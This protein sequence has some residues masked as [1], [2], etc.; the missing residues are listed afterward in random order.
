MTTSEQEIGI[1]TTD[2][3]LVVRSWDAWLARVTGISADVARGQPL[4]QLVPEL[5]SRGL[6]RR[7]ERVLA[8]GVVEVLAPAFHRHLIACAPQVPS[9]HFSTMQQWVTIAPLREGEWVVGTIVTVEDVTARLER[10]RELAG[11]L[12]SPDESIRLQAA[13]ALEAENAP[14]ELLVGALGDQSWRVRQSAVSGLA[15]HGGPQALVALLRALREQH[16]DPSVLNS[17]LQALALSDGDVVAPLVECLGA[18]EADLRIYA[19]L[20]LGERHDSL[21]ISA[22]LGALDDPD[23]NVRYHAIEA[24]GK[25]RAAEAVDTLLAIANSGDFFLAFPAIDALIRIGDTRAASRLAP[26][27]E[28]PLL[29]ALTAEAL[30]QLGDEAAVEP[31]VTL[32]NKPGAPALAIVQAL[33]GLHDRYEQSYGEGSYIADLARQSIDA[34]GAHNVLD[35][36]DQAPP[37]EL[38]ALVLVLGWLDGPAVQRTLA[39]LLG[40][41]AVRKTVVEA[42][43]RH[44]PRVTD[45]LIEQLAAEDLETR[46]AAALALGRIGDARA[47]P[48]LILALK[49]APELAMTAAG[50]LGAIGDRRAFEA[51]LDL[52]GHPIAAVRQAA[53]GALNS[54]G[55]PDLAACTLTLLDSP[56]PQVRESA[57][58]IAGYFG[59]DSCVDAV[60]AR[61]DDPD[62]RVRRAA[63]EHLPY[64]EDPRVL[65]ALAAALCSQSTGARAAAARALGQVEGASAAPHLLAALDDADPWV[66]YFA[67]RSIGQHGYPEALDAIDRLAQADPAGQVRI[68]ALEALGRIGGPRAAALLA[69]FTQ[70]ADLDIA[71][72]ALEAL[73][74]IDQPG[75]LPAL[76][77]AL[78]ADEPA[79]RI[80]ALRALAQR[81]GAAAV[82][83]L[84]R[85][86]ADDDAQVA[87]VAIEALAQVGGEEAVA[88]LSALAAGGTHRGACI[89]ALARQGEDRVEVVA[90]GLAHPAAGVRSV[91]VEALAQMKLPRASEHV[92]A[93]LDDRDPAV[94]L[95]AAR[96]LGQLGSHQA[97]RQLAALARSDPDLGV[98][99][100]AHAALRQ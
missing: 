90:R 77:A 78:R 75:A 44:G 68:A 17:A 95:V 28:D 99:R 1:L 16:R 32:L 30:G 54:L 50:A 83:P 93:A 74:A 47:A 31:L 61:C 60:L 26:L 82:E 76:Q 13:Q 64:L 100:A 92:R 52:V 36:L 70:D 37:S 59:Y 57:V 80:A 2:A 25:L 41:P 6:R 71:R 11:Q 62:E 67:L 10:E 33:A 34:A 9:R 8:E 49:D 87:Q 35:A 56:D 22:L 88:A 96:A 20:A 23:A 3:Q 42:L 73:G 85:A 84:L 97:E 7:F 4:A 65:P 45:L 51:L 5:E 18:P 63:I 94:R 46:Q 48:A 79:R 24:L 40:Q 12:A 72:A 39:R 53:V 27:L 91:V 43:V 15:R 19:A 98:R 29:R 14:A 55:H 58:K 38:R 81:G 21:A 86:A 69:P 66:R 89:K